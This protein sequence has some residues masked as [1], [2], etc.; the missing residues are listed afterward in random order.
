MN[1]NILELKDVQGFRVS[2]SKEK[3]VLAIKGL[4]FHSA[5]AVNSMRVDKKD[6]RFVI[7]LHL[8]QATKG[9]SGSFEYKISIPTD[10]REVCFGSKAV[11][12]WKEEH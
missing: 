3:R 6:N 10:V 8:V 9:L 4:A 1:Q 2:W 12:I 5:L 7:L 11:P